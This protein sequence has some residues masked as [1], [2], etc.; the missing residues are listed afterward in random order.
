MSGLL[1]VPNRLSVTVHTGPDGATVTAPDLAP[2]SAS[3]GW[4]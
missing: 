1:I 4:S 3:S 2:R